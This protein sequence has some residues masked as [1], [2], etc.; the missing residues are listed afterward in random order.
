MGEDAVRLADGTIDAPATFRVSDPE[1]GEVWAEGRAILK[2]GDPDYD[3]WDAWLK[4][5][6]D[7]G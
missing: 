4:L 2:P 1:L 5:P 7:P 6:A 3:A